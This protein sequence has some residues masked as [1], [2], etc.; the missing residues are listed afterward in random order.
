MP[1]A[2]CTRS[3]A[4]KQNKHTSVVTTGTP[5]R[6]GIPRANGLTV[7]FVVSPE[8]GLYCLRHRRDAKSILTDLIPASGYQDATTSPYADRALVRRAR[9]IHR[10]PRS[11]FVT[12]RNAPP[13]ECG[14][15]REMPLICR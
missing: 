14:T 7:S 9:R 13:D 6:S 4:C 10:I 12:T 11:T 5:K 15:G 3:L 2:R 8:T 1:G